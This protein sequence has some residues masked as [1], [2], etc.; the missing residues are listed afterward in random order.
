MV[1]AVSGLAEISY[2]HRMK[3]LDFDLDLE[4]AISAVVV[5]QVKGLRGGRGLLPIDQSYRG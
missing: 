2:G 1:K 4:H 5:P 3:V